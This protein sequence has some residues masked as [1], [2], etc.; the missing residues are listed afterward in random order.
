M[1]RVGIGYV[2]SETKKS[3]MVNDT[4]IATGFCVSQHWRILRRVL[5]AGFVQILIS[6]FKWLSLVP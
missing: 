6:V 5:Q 2:F 1:V 3:K 4:I